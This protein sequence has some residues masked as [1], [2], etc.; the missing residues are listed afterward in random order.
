LIGHG[1]L[2]SRSLL[3]AGSAAVC[4]LVW[5]TVLQPLSRWKLSVTAQSQTLRAD[6]QRLD[7]SLAALTAE[8]A[9]LSGNPALDMVWKA[10][11]AG[12]ASAVIQ[13]RLS[14]LA[15]SSG[16]SLRSITPLPARD[17]PLT[18]GVGFRLEFEAPLDRLT[19][20]LIA[21]EQSR[22][23]LAIERA[24]LRRLVRPASAGATTPAEQPQ[25]ELFVQIDIIAPVDVG[26]QDDGDDT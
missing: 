24:T 14:E 20:L 1:S 2:L 4:G 16:L 26:Q 22:P 7:S 5:L 25:P 12:Q 9:A 3:L 18:Q 11:Q 23:L 17:L 19:D 13:G 15:K 10:E 8:G 6:I 21:I